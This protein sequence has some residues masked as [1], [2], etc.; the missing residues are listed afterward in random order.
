[1]WWMRNG[2]YVG[3][4]LQ[5]YVYSRSCALFLTALNSYLCITR[6][7]KHLNVVCKLSARSNSG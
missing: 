5:L 4:A 1:M 7:S 2:M 6:G 3:A